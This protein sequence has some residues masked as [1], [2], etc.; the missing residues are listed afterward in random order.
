[1]SQQFLFHLDVGA[2]TAQHGGVGVPEG[3]PGDLAD[4]GANRR[5][6]QLALQN[7]FLPPRPT[8]IIG[9]NP[10]PAI[11]VGTAIVKVLQARRQ[12]WIRGKRTARALLFLSRPPDTAQPTSG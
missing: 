9:E 2:G 5:R 11:R 8:R 10:V 1:M 7:G 3:V 12:T 4:P 6:F